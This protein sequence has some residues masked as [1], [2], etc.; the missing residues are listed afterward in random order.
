MVGTN[1]TQRD[2][3]L[4]VSTWLDETQGPHR[5]ARAETYFSL[6]QQLS[7]HEQRHELVLLDGCAHS[8]TE[9]AQAKA[10]PSLIEKFCEHTLT[11]V[12]VINIRLEK[13]VNDDCLR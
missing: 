2:E 5:R 1:D 11:G 9:C 4:R 12:I 10:W 7:G 3:A 6:L 13:R 8:F